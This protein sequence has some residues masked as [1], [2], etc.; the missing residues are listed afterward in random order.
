[1]TTHQK[2]HGVHHVRDYCCVYLEAGRV[3]DVRNALPLGICEF[4]FLQQVNTLEHFLGGGRGIGGDGLWDRENYI[5]I[6]PVHSQVHAPKQHMTRNK[7]QRHTMV[8]LNAVNRN[9]STIIS[10]NYNRQQPIKE[11]NHKNNHDNNCGNS[12][13]NM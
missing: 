10:M 11:R 8:A 7:P 9:I 2:S 1:M 13:I 4:R 6:H 12:V 3:Q 5:Q